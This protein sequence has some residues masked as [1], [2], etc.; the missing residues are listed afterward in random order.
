MNTIQ[1]SP[2]LPPTSEDADDR[3][4]VEPFPITRSDAVTGSD[5]TLD[6]VES[7][8]TE[9]GASVVYGP[10]NCGKSFWAFDLAACVATGRHFRAEMEVAQGAVV[11]VA[12]EGRH[13]TRNRVEAMRR[14]GRLPDGSPFYLCFSPVS[15]LE[16]GHSKQLAE[17]VKAAA[18]QSDLPCRLVIIDTLA[19]AMAGG[20]ENG[21]KDMTRA[22]ESMDAVR[23]ATGAHV[24]LVHHCG[25]DEAKGARG[26]SSLRAAVDTE[27]ELSRPDGEK[28]TTV[29][30]TKQRDLEIGEA[31]PFSLNVIELGINQRGK[32]ITSCIVHHE[33]SVMAVMKKGGGRNKSYSP[34]ILLD[35]LPAESVKK[36]LAAVRDDTGM[37]P[38]TFYDFKRN[39][40]R[41][42]SLLKAT[43]GIRK[44][45][46]EPW[47]QTAQPVGNKQTLETP[48]TPK[49]LFGAIPKTPICL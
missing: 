24:M 39:L 42:G 25:K 19:R 34:E 5:E 20:D 10:S 2:T 35:Y 1:I 9:G 3:S 28:I 32:P 30:V 46:D 14:E 47:I 7:L 11:Y 29:R 17:S 23:Y 22:V 21:G 38:S 36:W 44:K 40:E 49:F 12:L 15:L 31:M 37:S 26:H 48:E 18:G 41:R 8:L 13:G 45:P 33:D 43:S 16:A 27:I 4:K 6:F